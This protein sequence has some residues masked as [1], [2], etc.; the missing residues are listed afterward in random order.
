MLSIPCDERTAAAIII[1]DV[2]EISMTETEWESAGTPT[3]GDTISFD[4]G[5][6]GGVYAD[7][8]QD[9]SYLVTDEFSHAGTHVVSFVPVSA[10]TAYDGETPQGGYETYDDADDLP[11]CVAS[12]SDTG[13]LS[14]IPGIMS[15]DGESTPAQSPDVTVDYD[16]TPEAAQVSP[17]MRLITH[18]MVDH[19]MS[20]REVGMG[21]MAL[22][23][24]RRK[25]SINPDVEIEIAAD[26]DDGEDEDLLAVDIRDDSDESP[27]LT[28]H[29]ETTD[30]SQT[31]AISRK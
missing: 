11:E 1:D 22:E 21:L 12:P 13:D 19:G 6:S 24:E 16:A 30:A 5:D 29:E 26:V 10:E 20:L 18:L 28:G 3:I 14:M 27:V 2:C 9:T 8:F 15:P 7:A 17:S 31:G 4:V 23:E 25:A